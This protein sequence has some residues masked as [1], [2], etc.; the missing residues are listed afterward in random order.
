MERSDIPAC[1]PLRYHN[2]RVAVN[3][4]VSKKAE[5]LLCV[6]FIVTDTVVV[7]GL[8]PFD[9]IGQLTIGFVG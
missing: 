7:T 4:V 3:Y 9:E 1:H 6:Y 5:N 2:G 8:P